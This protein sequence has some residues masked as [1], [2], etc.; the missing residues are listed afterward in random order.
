V[1]RLLTRFATVHFRDFMALQ[2]TPMIGM[3]AFHELP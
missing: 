1:A 2:L 3:T